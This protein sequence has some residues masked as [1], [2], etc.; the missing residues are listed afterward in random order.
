[1]TDYIVC[2]NT[3]NCIIYQKWNEIRKENRVNVIHKK[4]PEYRCVALDD[5]KDLDKDE[6]NTCF[7]LTLINLLMK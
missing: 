5:L 1:M 2:S 4:G 7:N 6:E 3:K